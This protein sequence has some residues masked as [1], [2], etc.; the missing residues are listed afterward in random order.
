MF[1]KLK[2]LNK[3]RKAQSDIKKQMENI[4]V[5]SE[6]GRLRIVIRGD[7]RIEKLEIDGEDDKAL[8][9]LLNDAFKD[10]DKKVE[11]QMRGQLQDLGLP[12]L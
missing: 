9:E 11:K 10:V 4:F 6:R 5:T 3:L 8:R 7:K 12:G 2:D 1:D